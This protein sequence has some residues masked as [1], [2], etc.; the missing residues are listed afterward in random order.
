MP[1]AEGIKG[2]ARNITRQLL[3]IGTEE[4]PYI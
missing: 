1:K 2:I 3:A 4:Y